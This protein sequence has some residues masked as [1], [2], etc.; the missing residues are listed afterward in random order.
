MRIKLKFLLTFI[1]LSLFG[2]NT[3]LDKRTTLTF[4]GDSII[5]R[6]DLQSYFS[7]LITY[8]QGR[9]GEGIKYIESL[10]GK[11]KGK[12]VVI[13]IGTND[14]YMMREE[15]YRSDYVDRYI[16][17]IN[18]MDAEVVYLFEVLPR[19]FAGDDVDIN[20]YIPAFNNEVAEKIKDYSNVR[21]IKVFDKFVDDNRRIIYR[22]YNDGLHLSPEG[23]EVLA[24]ALFERI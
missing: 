14:S 10:A 18:G 3:E 2:C 5:A 19:E 6:W 22:F 17:A 11:M 1:V 21:Y 12:N 9:S 20:Q 8:N 4:V 13:M 7:S 23:Y 24:N 16:S 15:P